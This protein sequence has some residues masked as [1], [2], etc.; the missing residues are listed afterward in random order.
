M[1]V[2]HLSAA[3]LSSLAFYVL[4]YSGLALHQLHG[5]EVFY[6]GR[7]MQNLAFLSGSLPASQ[8]FV[9]APNHPFS[10]ETFIGLVMSL[11]GHALP[12]PQNPWTTKLTIDQ[13]ISA[14]TASLLV[15][16]LGAGALV[17]F[18]S[19]VKPALAVLAAA[20]LFS[21]PGYLDI[22]MLAWLDVYLAVF[23][24]LSLMALY[25]YMKGRMVALPFSG[26]FLGLALGS[27]L[28]W[29]PILAGGVIALGILTCAGRPLLARARDMAIL[30]ITAAVA[31]AATN[32]VYIATLGTQLTAL[33]PTTGRMSLNNLFVSQS[34]VSSGNYSIFAMQQP[35]DVA[36]FLVSLAA[37]VAVAA[38]RG[39]S[40]EGGRVGEPNDT[41]YAFT[42]LVI[43]FVALD[44]IMTGSTFEYGRNYERAPVYEA[45]AI[46]CVQG[47]VLAEVKGR[48]AKAAIL[49]AQ[50]AVSF[51]AVYALIDFYASTF[52]STG[53]LVGHSVPIGNVFYSQA[54][55]W[56]LLSLL[57]V[58]PLA[59]VLVSARAWSGRVEA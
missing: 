9:S 1:K 31:F 20:F 19:D 13:L 59:A 36:L 7:E 18:A 22:S 55:G 8:V 50:L 42:A 57:V 30:A 35:L 41:L 43:L 39:R 11:T 56:L 21:V 28:G 12:P 34:I 10:G 14:R 46:V 33:S 16:S 6:I 3:F 44:L 49:G 53:W 29:D 37:F 25:W 15:G 27:K 54:E 26:A 17:Y 47:L 32:L 48:L 51:V 2:A 4:F 38:R 45:L 24:A 5:D 58:A 40:M 23:T 52:P